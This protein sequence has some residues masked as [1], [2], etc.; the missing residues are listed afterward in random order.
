MIYFKRAGLLE[1]AVIILESYESRDGFCKVE[2]E[3]FNGMMEF[4]EEYEEYQNLIPLLTDNNSNYWCFISD[5]KHKGKVC[6]LS[7]DE[8]DLKPLFSSVQ[9]LINEINDHP[10]AYDFYELLGI[11]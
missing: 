9:D 8:I 10:D 1:E 3:D 4:F 2:E 11:D 6:H 5:G 7:H